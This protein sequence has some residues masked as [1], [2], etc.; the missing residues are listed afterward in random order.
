LQKGQNKRISTHKRGSAKI[1]KGA[2]PVKNDRAKILQN[3]SLLSYIGL[4][5]VVPIVG[6]VYL[7]N[8]LDKKLETGNIFL[9]I[10]ILLGIAAGFLNVYK[11]LMKDIKKK[12]K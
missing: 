7:G 10:F 5:M 2:D 9:M 11:I 3:L 8:F 6:A 4:M 1:M 12:K